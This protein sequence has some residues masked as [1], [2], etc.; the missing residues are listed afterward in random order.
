MKGL[1]Y[2]PNAYAPTFG[3]D[4]LTI[5]YN[6]H[7]HAAYG[8]G[9]TL[10]S[11]YHPNSEVIYMTD[12]QGVVAYILA[13]LRPFFPSLHHSASG[14]SNFLIFWSN[15][16]AAI[17][18][19]LCFLRL[20]IRTSLAII[21]AVLIA[22]MSPQITRQV[23]GHY[24]LGYAFLIPLLMYFLV[25]LNQSLKRN[26]ANAI[27]LILVLI[28]LGVN[29]P[30]LLAISGSFLLAFSGIG[31][32]AYLLFKKGQLS[33]IILPLSVTV[34][35]LAITGS[36]L[37]SL[38][39][40]T[41]RTKVP[42]GFF[43]NLSTMKSIFFPGGTLPN[44]PLS[45]LFKSG[46]QI[47]E[48]TAYIGLIPFLFLLSLPFI[49]IRKKGKRTFSLF[50]QN[51]LGHILLAS[52]IVLLFALGIPFIYFQE[53]TLEH[54]G[55][56]L[57]FRAPGRFSWI[58]Y[59]GISIISAV[60]VSKWIESI[61]NDGHKKKALLIGTI[62]VALWGLEVHQFLHRST[63]GKI[64]HNAF[65]KGRLD[66]YRQK[67]EALNLNGDIYEGIFLIPTEHGWTDKVHHSGE[68]RSNYEGYR[69]SLASGLPLINGKLSRMS[70]SQCLAS[71][72]LLAD[73]MVKKDLL[74]QFSQ[75]KDILFVISLEDELTLQED[76]LVNS[77]K[78]I[79]RTDKYL[80]SS[81]NIKEFITRENLHRQTIINNSSSA[82]D[83]LA[84]PLIHDPMDEDMT[85]AFAG[86]GGRLI[87]AGEEEILSFPLSNSYNHD[88]L[89]LSFWY[90]VDH[91]YSGGPVWELVCKKEGKVRHQEKLHGLDLMR[92][93]DGWMK[94]LFQLAVEE[95]LESV[96]IESSA[97]HP[98]Y[99]DELL[100]RRIQ[101]TIFKRIDGELIVNNYRIKN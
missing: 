56:V 81:I 91:D 100:V 80:L 30:Y 63:K 37:G 61:L 1:M 68:F 73:P 13:T 44:E 50:N 64:H 101:D 82:I 11:Q 67:V 72:Q 22:L 88:T 18:L 43:S 93:Q 14:I 86:T 53:W 45:A 52:V 21:F 29:N 90:H 9:A 12:A 24:A 96:T 51:Y 60:G 55:T 39:L 20:K 41:D 16:L 76:R 77:A 7:Y 25:S 83:S 48:G 2:A 23:G 26:I 28:I 57:Q 92:T 74:Y 84:S 97:R 10:K 47:N 3:G 78:E 62:V 98:Y 15:P 27:A 8:E 42:Y 65:N 99:I 35:S 59:Y 94:A 49:L 34:I 71:M 46:R 87:N 19:F 75:E 31:L 54:L 85:H 89:E 5:H 4:G 40:I 33:H 95:D 69:Y 70:V 6:L 32:L 66:D 17:V 36:F 79:Y 58:F 38:D